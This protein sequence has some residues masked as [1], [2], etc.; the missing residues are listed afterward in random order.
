[1]V[2]ERV[3][4]DAAVNWDNC[5]KG[6][7]YWVAMARRKLSTRCRGGRIRSFERVISRK[8]FFSH[9]ATTYRGSHSQLTQE[10]ARSW[11][12]PSRS[13]VVFDRKRWDRVISPGF[14]FGMRPVGNISKPRFF[15]CPCQAHWK[16]S[17]V[18]NNSLTFLISMRSE[19][20]LPTTLLPNT[21]SH[22]HVIR[23]S[24]HKFKHS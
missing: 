6:V 23:L 7:T 22:T 5:S 10:I 24:S 14:R 8:N 11:S 12:L 9:W 18:R 3:S 13:F 4:I 21:Q 17:F 2:G 1:M 19:V 16:T 15:S 20:I